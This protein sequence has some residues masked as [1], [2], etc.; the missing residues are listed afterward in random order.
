MPPVNCYHVTLID[1]RW[2]AT[3]IGSEGPA[4]TF[5]SLGAALANGIGVFEPEPA[6]DGVYL[7][8]M[9]TPAAEVAKFAKLATS[10]IKTGGGWRGQALPDCT[11]QNR[12]ALAGVD[13]L[14]WAVEVIHYLKFGGR[15]ACE[16]VRDWTQELTRLVA[17]N[18]IPGIAAF[19]ARLVQIEHLLNPQAW[20]G[21]RVGATG[22]FCAYTIVGARRDR[23][24]LL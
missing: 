3:P 1:E 16:E 23:L 7:W 14:I 9:V 21:R 4:L 5:P 6:V 12:V 8:R 10:A 15:Q 11:R 20:I 24:P 13:D 2:T 19:Y 22:D 18:D 17:N